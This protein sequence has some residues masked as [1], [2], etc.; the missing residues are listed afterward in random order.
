MLFIIIGAMTWLAVVCTTVS[1][2]V[3]WWGIV[4]FGALGSVW[5]IVAGEAVSLTS[6]SV[7]ILRDVR[8]A[9]ATA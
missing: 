1:L 2:L 9:A 3:A 6:I 5:G 4:Q 8:R 7:M